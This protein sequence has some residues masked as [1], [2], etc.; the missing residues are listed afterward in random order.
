MS[1]KLGTRPETGPMRFHGD[2]TG[3]FIRGDNALG[4]SHML[5]ES[6]PG[7]KS[8]PEMRHVVMML[9]RLKDTLRNCAEHSSD[10]VQELPAFKTIADLTG[11]LPTGPPDRSKDEIRLSTLNELADKV[12]DDT[13]T[14]QI[15]KVVREADIGFETSGGSTRHW[16][17]D[18]FLPLLEKAGLRVVQFCGVCNAPTKDSCHC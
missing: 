11:D 5:N 7:L 16:V 10:R 1:A 9:T 13:I 6:I 3:I 8:N 12:R 4:I 18:Q 17:R 14:K 2:W 15:T